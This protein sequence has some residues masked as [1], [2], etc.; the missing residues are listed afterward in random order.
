MYIYDEHEENQCIPNDSSYKHFI[1]L[2][3]SF[4]T[5]NEK[6]RILGIK[7]QISLISY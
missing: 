4:G 7:T 3:V 1:Y 2:P 6:H 5:I